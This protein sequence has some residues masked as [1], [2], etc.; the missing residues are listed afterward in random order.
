MLF[1]FL[2]D[3]HLHILRQYYL[4]KKVTPALMMHISYY[5]HLEADA[6]TL[7]RIVP[8]F[9]YTSFPLLLTS[10]SSLFDHSFKLFTALWT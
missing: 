2:F 1:S 8:P 10:A 9:A 6:R 3:S 4:K 7:Y 5:H